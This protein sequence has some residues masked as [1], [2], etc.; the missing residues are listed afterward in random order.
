[1]SDWKAVEAGVSVEDVSRATNKIEAETEHGERQNQNSANLEKINTS[2][3]RSNVIDPFAE[4]PDGGLNAWLKVLGCFLIYSNICLSY[5]SSKIT[6][7]L[8]C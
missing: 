1:M 7:S 2:S 8:K 3:G 4:P 5:P 6:F